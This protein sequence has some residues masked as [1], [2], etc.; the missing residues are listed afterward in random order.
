MSVRN[1]TTDLKLSTSDQINTVLLQSA[2]NVNSNIE[3]SINANIEVAEGKEKYE[4]MAVR[5]TGL[6]GYFI[7]DSN[8]AKKN[9]V[10]EFCYRPR[11]QFYN[12]KD[13]YIRRGT[14]V[15]QNKAKGHCNPKNK[16]DYNS[17]RS[18]S[19][20]QVSVKN[21]GAK[22]YQ[23]KADFSHYNLKIDT[24]DQGSLKNMIEVVSTSALPSY[25]NSTSTQIS[26]CFTQGG[27][28]IQKCLTKVNVA[29]KA[30]VQRSEVFD[31][32]T[33][34]YCKYYGVE[35]NAGA[36]ASCK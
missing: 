5:T 11:N 12:I 29:S 16:D 13:A 21:L 32:S 2:D 3:Q 19:M 14:G 7:S 10:I 23:G 26:E 8:G 18:I 31:M 34:E 25:G 35:V 28:A 36:S 24:G 27:A 17:N 15:L 30:L 1:S 20:T 33:T 6:L 22:G 9:D 4:S